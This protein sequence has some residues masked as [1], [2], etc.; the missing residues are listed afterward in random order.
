MLQGAG[1]WI[2]YYQTR[3]GILEP[4]KL[5]GLQIFS[6]HPTTNNEYPYMRVL[7]SKIAKRNQRKFKYI[8]T[9][10]AIMAISLFFCFVVAHFYP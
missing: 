2:D 5:K 6:N 3:L 4:A 10:S 1:F 9:R 8:S 7:N